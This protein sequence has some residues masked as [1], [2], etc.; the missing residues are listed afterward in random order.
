[1]PEEWVSRWRTA[2]FA[3]LGGSCGRCFVTLSSGATFP[4]STSI[5]S[6]TAVNCFVSEPI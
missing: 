2:I 5:M 6:A 1:M 3:H 4:S